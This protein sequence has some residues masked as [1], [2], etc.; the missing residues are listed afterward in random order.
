MMSALLSKHFLL[1]HPLKLYYRK[2]AGG[3]GSEHGIG[4]IYSIPP[5]LQRGHG[6]G[7]FLAP[8]FAGFGP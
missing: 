2:Q 3:G 4:P 5:Y 1:K 7:D 8:C 6:I